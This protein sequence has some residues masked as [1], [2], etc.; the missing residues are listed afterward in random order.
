MISGAAASQQWYRGAARTLR[1]RAGRTGRLERQPRGLQ[2]PANEGDTAW[3]DARRRQQFS[4]GRFGE[5]FQGVEVQGVQ[6]TDHWCLQP[7]LLDSCGTGFIT[8]L[9]CPSELV[10]WA[11]LRIQCGSSG[12]G[13]QLLAIAQPDLE[14]PQTCSDVVRRYGKKI[15]H[16]SEYP[17]GPL[18]VIRV[19]PQTK[20]HETFFTAHSLLPIRDASTLP[21][22]KLLEGASLR[23]EARKKPAET[24]SRATRH[25]ARIWRSQD[26]LSHGAPVPAGPHTGGA[27]F[28]SIAADFTRPSI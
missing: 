25:G 24:P 12:R 20:R 8:W 15:V 26:D 7:D 23:K 6:L 2:V 18:D 3:T 11:L 9:I 14:R 16:R 1:P 28:L 22:L 13:V 5:V 21:E 10:R 17:D 4:L 27:S 19:C